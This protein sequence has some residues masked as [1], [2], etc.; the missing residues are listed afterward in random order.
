MGPARA[1]T[2]APM[3]AGTAATDAEVPVRPGH[4]PSLLDIAQAVLDDVRGVLQARMHLLALE[5]R[6]A[7]LALTLMALYA[8]LA[9]LL[10]LTAWVCGWV[11]AITLAVAAGLPMGAVLVAALLLSA[12]AVWLLLRMARAEA[13]HLLFRATVRQ[14]APSRDPDGGPL[15]PSPDAPPGVAPRAAAM[16]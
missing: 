7:G 8:V 16:P 11:L 12:L 3:T 10:A 13:R 1:D 6:R 4:A 9:A 15:G 14:L 2:A 5:A